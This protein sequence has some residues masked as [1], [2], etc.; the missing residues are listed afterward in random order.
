MRNVFDS[1]DDGAIDTMMILLVVFNLSL[2]S[3]MKICH[4]DD[5]RDAF[6]LR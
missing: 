5:D 6:Q 4:E 2:R 1:G 3:L